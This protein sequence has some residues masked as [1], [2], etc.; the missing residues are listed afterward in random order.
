MRALFSVLLKVHIMGGNEVN[1]VVVGELVL[2]LIID[3]LVREQ[4][5]SIRRRQRS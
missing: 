4:Q 5:T 2:F 3:D 1:A